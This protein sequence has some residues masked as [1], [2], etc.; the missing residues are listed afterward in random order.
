MASLFDPFS[1]RG[2]T[3]RNRI[4][5]S[6]MCQYS[7]T[8]G[9][10]NDWHLVHLGSRAVGGAGLVITEAT[11][12]SPE[13]RISP[14]DLGLYD[15]RHVEM[16]HRITRFIAEQG[17]VPGIQ[18]AHAGRKASTRRPWEGGKPI[19]ISEGGWEPI[20]PSPIPFDVRSPTP[21][22]MD[23]ADR[24]K[25]KEDF[26]RAAVR[27]SA[28]GFAW[29]ELHA[30][31][32]YL[33]HGFLS[34]IS[35]QRTDSYGGAFEN[36]VRFPLEVVREVR[37]AWPKDKPLAV[38]LSCTDWVE[39]GWDIE[40]SVA[41]ASLL[42]DAGVDLIDCSSGGTVPQARIP[43]A[44]GYQ[45]PF[46]ARIKQDAEIA[47]SAV[48]LIARPDQAEEIVSRG[49]ADLVFLAREFLRDPYWPL[50]HAKVENGKR[51]PEPPVQYARAF[52]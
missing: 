44:P 41:L 32:G 33:L 49:R 28:A 18:L 25:V 39:G 20:A 51:I 52:T 2:V 48:G 37:G 9:F 47:T 14:N 36:R 8:D 23:A 22:A 15:D 42:K 10:A 30:A 1:L 21:K 26:R 45:V 46:S 4:G 38:R 43:L 34:P 50:R 11:G 6:P 7:S 13:G 29:L 3:L 31:H 16:L 27:A 24:E 40:Q 35:N 19:P 5:V 12:V 17:A